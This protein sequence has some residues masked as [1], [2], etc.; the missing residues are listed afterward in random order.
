MAQNPEEGKNNIP[1]DTTPNPLENISKEQPPATPSVTPPSEASQKT[2]KQE[3]QPKDIKTLLKELLIES[4]FT[5]RIYQFVILLSGLYGLYFS[6]KGQL[7]SPVPAI[8]GMLLLALVALFDIYIIKKFRQK[9][10]KLEIIIRLT[11]AGLFT[12]FMIIFIIELFKPFD[13]TINK[14]LILVCFIAAVAIFVV[15][16]LLYIK[17][18]KEKIIADVYMFIAILFA[19]ISV[20]VFYLYQVILSFFLMLIA[21]ASIIASINNDPLKRDDRFPTRML[22]IFLTGI[23]FIFVFAYASLIFM[24]KPLPVITFGTLSDNF[25][26]KP[27]NLSWS[28]DSWSFAYNIFDKKKHENK[29]GIIN[30]LTLGLTELP[31]NNSNI[32]LPKI[33]DK[34]IW[35]NNGSKLIFTASNSNDEYKKIWGINLNI[36]LVKEKKKKEKIEKEKKLRTS[37]DD[38]LNRPVGKPKVL[39]SDINLI[40]DKDC[41]PVTHRT[42][43]SSDGNRF[44]FAAKDD[45]SNNNNIWIADTKNQEYKRI[46]TGDNKIMPLWSPADNKILYVTRTDSYPYIKISDYDNSNAHE[47]NINKKEDRI[48]FPLWNANES[49]VIYI[50]NNKLIIMNANATNQQ[51]LSK[52]T[53][54]YSDYWLTDTKKKVKLIYTESGTIWRIFTIDSEGNN[55]KEIFTEVCDSM[56]QPKWSNDG[57]AICAGTNYVNYS[58]L[59]LLNKNGELKTK[60][61]TSKHKI[62]ILEWDPSSKRIAF[63]LEK[64]IKDNIWYNESHDKIYE[65]WVVERDGTNPRFIYE[66]IGIINNISWDDMGKNIAFDE[67]YS[68]WYFAPRITTIKVANVIDNTVT[69]LLPY[70]SYAEYPA[71]SNDGQVLAYIGWSEFWRPTL[72]KKIWIAQIK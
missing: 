27:E 59:W 63:L 35:N 34:P 3:E 51:E 71:W 32:K 69:D 54:V 8:V 6:T 68:K 18:N 16:F 20:S 62:K 42:A 7:F 66:S 64:N 12:L 48:L 29:I 25:S 15:N 17:T 45:N 53:L 36:S 50:K 10:E 5:N 9:Y 43:W 13:L 2:E 22:I 56:I 46:T 61:F 1:K 65:I 31:A 44:V 67:T 24:K 26:N 28:G 72:S 47:L 40:V 33:V 58:S 70:E 21:G 55:P 49:K 60:L 38:R 57:D 41:L 39:L 23:M 11:L 19:V 14:N 30:A 37:E 52:Q 4:Q